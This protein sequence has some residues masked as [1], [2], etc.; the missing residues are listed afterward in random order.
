MSGSSGDGVL[1]SPSL[2]VRTSNFERRG[3]DESLDMRDVSEDAGRDADEEGREAEV[4]E[5][6]AVPDFVDLLVLETAETASEAARE[7]DDTVRCLRTGLTLVLA[8]ESSR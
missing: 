5:D 7:A 6:G 3:D 2:L 8:R 4:E 1:L